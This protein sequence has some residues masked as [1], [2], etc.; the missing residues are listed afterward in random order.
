MPR[1]QTAGQNLPILDLAHR[2]EPQ[3]FLS[4]LVAILL[5]LL[6]IMIAVALWS[7]AHRL[8][9]RGRELDDQQWKEILLQRFAEL[10]KEINKSD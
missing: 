10:E 8:R 4:F 1:M 9:R 2:L 5:L 6:A 7:R 3:Q